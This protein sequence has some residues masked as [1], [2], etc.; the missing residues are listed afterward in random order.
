[1]DAVADVGVEGPGRW[2]VL[3]QLGDRARHKQRGDQ[4]EDDREDRSAAAEGH[5]DGMENAVAM[6]GA[7]KVIDWNKI[8]LKPTAPPRSSA[9]GRSFPHAVSG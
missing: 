9:G 1:M 6:A 8:S 2:H 7:M 4:G 5:A 3:G